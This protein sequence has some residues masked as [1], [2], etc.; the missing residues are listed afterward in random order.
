[1]TGQRRDKGDGSIYQRKSDGKWIAKYTHTKGVKPKVIYGKTESEAKKK[2]RE[3]K[4]EIAKNG[5]VEIQKGTVKSYMEKWFNE[6]KV[7][8]LK[9][10]SLDALDSTLRNQVYPHIGD[11]QLSTITSKD[12]QAML[13][14][15]AQQRTPRDKP[16]A[17]ST[18][19]KAYMAVNACFKHAVIHEDTVKNPCLGVKL[20]K[21]VNQKRE[22]VKF[23]TQEQVANI[24]RECVAKHSND[25][26]V[27]RLGQAI[28]VLVYTGMRIGELLGLKWADI[29]YDKR[30]GKVYD[31][32]VMVKDRARNDGDATPK[33]KLLEQTSVKTSS[34]SRIVTLNQKAISALQEIQLIN[35][36]YPHVMANSKGKIIIPR[37]FDRM[38][39]NVLERCGIEPSGAH[40]LRHTYASMLFKNRVDVK[41]VSELLGHK[42]VAFTYNTYI[43]L[44]KEQ[45]Q[46][47]VDILDTL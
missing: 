40:T 46:Q 6:I 28:I 26:Q 29:D 41:T 5:Y 23:F 43:H 10:K 38:L 35:G 22:E 27:Y 13:N 24:C 19:K 44:I 12:V 20:P 14:E 32:V 7:N 42:D 8:E 2:L 1:M 4:K 17:Y 45:K 37:N 25:K 9:P 33:Y 21:N 36:E 39:R 11:I 16:L 47:A 3:Y 18:I 31:S 15:L 34:S 30:T